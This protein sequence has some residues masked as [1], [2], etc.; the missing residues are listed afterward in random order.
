[1]LTATVPS[2][3]FDDIS[4]HRGESPSEPGNLYLRGG[5]RTVKSKVDVANGTEESVPYIARILCWCRSFKQQK[6]ASI[7]AV[8]LLFNIKNIIKRN[9]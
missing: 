7:D 8:I 3:V 5:R 2:V 6:T 9:I 4:S 1:M